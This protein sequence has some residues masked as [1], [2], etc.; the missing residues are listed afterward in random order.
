[1]KISKEQIVTIAGIAGTV[2]SVGATLLTSWS[3]EQKTN[4]VIDKKVAEALA[5]QLSENK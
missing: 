1:M 2:L 4:E 3:S 5:K